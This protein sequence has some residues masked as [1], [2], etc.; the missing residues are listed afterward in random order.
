MFGVQWDLVLK[1]LEN[2]GVSQAE[3]KT[4]STNWGNYKNNLWNITNTDSKYYTD[5]KW[6]SG[7]YGKKASE[8]EVLL[9]TGANDTFGKQ[10]IYDFAGN[11]YEWTLEYT[12]NS[13]IPCASRGGS[14]YNDSNDCPAV[15]HYGIGTTNYYDSVGFRVSLY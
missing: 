4:S 6:T 7:A 3:L 8:T 12:S 1:Y 15:S 13:S 9:S 5:S 2:K 11:I 14:F 10:G